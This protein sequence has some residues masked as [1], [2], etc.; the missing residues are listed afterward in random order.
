MGYEFKRE[1]P[2]RVRETAL[3]EDAGADAEIDGPALTLS[4]TVAERGRLV[5]PAEVRERLQIHDGDRLALVVDADGTIRLQTWDV[6]AR[7]LL[8]A[9]KHLS[10]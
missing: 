6:L 1:R 5:L 9:Y 8:G 4:V 3:A 2:S 7:S 10:P